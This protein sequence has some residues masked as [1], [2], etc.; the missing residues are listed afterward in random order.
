L[1]G[2]ILE[3]MENMLPYFDPIQLNFLCAKIKEWNANDIRI[4]PIR[5]LL[6]IL[7]PKIHQLCLNTTLDSLC[8]FNRLF[9]GIIEEIQLIALEAPK[10]SDCDLL[11]QWLNTERA[12]G[13][14]KTLCMFYGFMINTN[15]MEEINNFIERV[16]QVGTSRD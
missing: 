9:P 12:D 3:F 15:T 14:P 10:I 1:D 13:K 7:A 6:S 11:L 4:G 2:P 16:K 5:R 8:D